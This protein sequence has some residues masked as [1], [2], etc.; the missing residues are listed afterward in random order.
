MAEDLTVEELFETRAVSRSDLVRAVDAYMSD[1]ATGLFKF[2]SGH[3]LDLVGAVQADAYA[4][5]VLGDAEANLMRKR[6]VVRMAL[7]ASRP[8]KG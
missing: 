6:G 7:M 1:P 4:Q 2:S 8:A 5:Q 3:V